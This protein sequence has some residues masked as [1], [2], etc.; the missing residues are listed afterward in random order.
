MIFS[1]TGRRNSLRRRGMSLL[2]VLAAGMLALTACSTA[3][4]E[5]SPDAGSTGNSTVAAAD[6]LELVLSLRDVSNPYHVSMIQGAELYADY[7]GKDL[8]IL[9]NDGD[10]QKQM[11]QI[12]TLVA[13]GKIPVLA[14]EAQTSSDA[15]PIVEAVVDAGGYV[16][17]LMNKTGDFWPEDVGDG[18][19][20]HVTFDNV[21][22][23]YDIAKTLFDEMGGK[24]GVI[25]LRGILDTPTDQQRWAGLE[26]ALEEYPDIELLDVQ[27]ADF[28][29]DLGFE[30]TETLLNKHGDA[31]QAIWSSNDDMALGAVEALKKADRFGDVFLAG[32]DGTPEAI[33]LIQDPDSGFLA[34]V[35]PDGA[36]QGGAGLALAY[37][38][39][40]GE[41]K[42]ADIPEA[43]RSFNAEQFLVTAENAEKFLQEPVLA[44][45]EA[46]FNDP[47]G[48][49]VSPVAR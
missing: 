19:V 8:K 3:E 13:G 14:V 2:A 32:V 27:T 21:V 9:A 22:S 24:G 12:Q 26:M 46:D 18:W 33:E 39:A 31:V 16:V 30:V 34:T 4:P 29:R 47:Y 37:Q 10:S 48:R 36:W 42:V 43:E 17:T 1:R 11:S 20:A 25:A 35:S 5:T 15:R 23:G 28:R 38:A 45:L 49:Y 40:T 41:L 6:D 44:D 7:I